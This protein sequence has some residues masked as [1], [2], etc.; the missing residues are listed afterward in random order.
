MRSGRPHLQWAGKLTASA[1]FCLA[2]VVGGTGL[3]FG[4][5]AF[6]RA[7]HEAGGSFFFFPFFGPSG[8][9]H[10]IVLPAS[11]DGYTRSATLGEH[12]HANTLAQGVTKSSRGSA[13]DVVS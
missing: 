5:L 10:E 8:P 7:Q 12:M 2:G 6:A 13:S 3:Y 4:N 9:T 1:A 11:V